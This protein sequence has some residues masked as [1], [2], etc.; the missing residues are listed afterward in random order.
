[1]NAKLTREHE[2]GRNLKNTVTLVFTELTR[3]ESE[4]YY[5][6]LMGFLNN[7][8]DLKKK[9]FTKRSAEQMWDELTKKK[10]E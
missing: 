3:G 1:M 5:E 4:F 7:S 6:A 10:E 2:N 9:Y 8:E